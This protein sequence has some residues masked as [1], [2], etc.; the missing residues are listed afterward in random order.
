[1]NYCIAF[2][3][4]LLLQIL[5]STSLSATNEVIPTGSYII[6]MGVLPPLLL[7][8]QS[9]SDNTCVGGNITLTATPIGGTGSC[10]I[11]WQKSADSGANWLDIFGANSLIYTI[12]N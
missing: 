10:G 6:N 8:I 2:M 5:V 4:S 1:M 7:L 12:L 11:Q 3:S 9:S